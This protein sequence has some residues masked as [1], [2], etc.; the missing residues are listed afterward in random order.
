MCEDVKFLGCLLD[1]G[2]VRADQAEVIRI[3]LSRE[4]RQKAR[5]SVG[6]RAVDERGGDPCGRPRLG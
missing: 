6:A 1:N 4:V 2:V 5:R 3:T